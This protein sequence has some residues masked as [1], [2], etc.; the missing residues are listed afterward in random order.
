M[1][2][3]LLTGLT[4]SPVLLT[5]FITPAVAKQARPDTY[6]YSGKHRT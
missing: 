6:D 5:R 1:I 4:L 2:V 3:A